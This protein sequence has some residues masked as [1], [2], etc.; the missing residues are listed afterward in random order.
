MRV[1]GLTSGSSVDGVGVAVAQLRLAG[2][3]VELD[4]LE[5]RK[6]TYPAPLRNALLA[7][8]APGRCTA[9]ELC[10]LDTEVGWAF[11][12]AAAGIDADLVAILGPPIHQ[13]DG[14]TLR[15][16]QPAPVAE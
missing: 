6:I 4:A 9:A 13:A 10:R 15:L 7:A 12:E 3:T 5:H 2:A 8:L 14:G 1:I 11:A 16:G